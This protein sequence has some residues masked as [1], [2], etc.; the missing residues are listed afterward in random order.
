MDEDLAPLEPPEV[1]IGI[2]GRSAAA[3][4]AVVALPAVNAALS[5]TLDVVGMAG[6]GWYL[7]VTDAFGTVVWSL[8]LVGVG[9]HVP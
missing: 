1:V 5:P 2:P 8:R 4:R 7:R 6:S 9:A 3:G